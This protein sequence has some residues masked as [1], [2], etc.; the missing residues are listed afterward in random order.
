[1][2]RGMS[3]RELWRQAGGGYYAYVSSK[4]S[5]DLIIVDLNPNNNG[6]TADAMSSAA[7]SS[8]LTRDMTADDTVIDDRLYQGMG[9]QGVLPIPLVYN[10]W[11]QKLPPIL[12]TH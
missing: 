11:V 5:N 12:L 4:F 1:M 7:S 2:Q 10:G 9:G 8:W 3:R 6:E